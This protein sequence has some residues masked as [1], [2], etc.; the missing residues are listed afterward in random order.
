MFSLNNSI[1]FYNILLLMNVFKTFKLFF[2]TVNFLRA[3]INLM[4][5]VFYSILKYLCIVGT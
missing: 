1:K 3:R 5:F 4:E 2:M